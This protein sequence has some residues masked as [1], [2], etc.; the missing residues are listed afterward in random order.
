MTRPGANQERTQSELTANQRHPIN[1]Q[2]TTTKI[3]QIK[4]MKYSVRY[5]LRQK[6][7]KES[8][9]QRCYVFVRVSWDGKQMYIGRRG[10]TNQEFVFMLLTPAKRILD[11]YGGKLPI[12]SNQKY[13]QQLKNIAVM[14]GI[15]GA[16]S[17]HW[18]RHTG[19]TLL[20]NSGAEMEIVSKVL[21]HSSTK[22]TRE[23]YAKLLDD[24]VAKAMEKME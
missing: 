6:S 20:L 24:T 2:K 4:V 9:D 15:N 16:L 7:E 10:K 12:M 21:G 3:Q 5:N 18:A 23:V 17:S 19:A 13:N 11:S 8:G 22:I 14:A 1:R